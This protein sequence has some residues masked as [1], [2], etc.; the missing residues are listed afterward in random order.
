M[1]FQDSTTSPHKTFIHTF[2]S[3]PQ[4]SFCLVIRC[5]DELTLDH[6]QELLESLL[7]NST[8]TYVITSDGDVFL[9]T[10][11]LSVYLE[12]SILPTLR[13]A[14]NLWVSKPPCNE[15]ITI[16]DVM[17]GTF[18][19]PK[20]HIESLKFDSNITST[21]KLLVKLKNLGFDFVAWDWEKF[22]SD[23]GTKDE[24]CNQ[25][26]NTTTSD[27]VYSTMKFK[28]QMFLK[29]FDFPCNAT[30][31]PQISGPQISGPQIS[32]PQI[33]GPQISG[34]QISGPQISGPQISGS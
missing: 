18:A 16:L 13:N 3:Y 32:G 12:L 15:C 21:M 8:N 6:L 9:G 14:T 17:F 7:G 28:I 25:I 22:L 34:P 30:S 26:I 24:Q 27:S 19:K 20:L 29:M 4:P 31:G 2:C 1:A 5:L 23:I 10:N 11:E 33:S